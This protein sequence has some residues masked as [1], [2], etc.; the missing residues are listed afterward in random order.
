MEFLLPT[1]EII[2]SS[3]VLLYFARSVKRCHG[4]WPALLDMRRRIFD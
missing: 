4:I 1:G 3:L 2:L